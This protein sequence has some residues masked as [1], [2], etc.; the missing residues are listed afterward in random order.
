VVYLGAYSPDFNP[1][2]LWWA[3]LK[4]QVRTRAPRAVD[5]LAQMVRQ[6]RAATPLVKLAACFRRCLSFPQ[7]N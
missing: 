3:A 5:E 2:E 1:I 6:L 4:R 7:L